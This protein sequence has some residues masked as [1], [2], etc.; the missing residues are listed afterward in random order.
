MRL[1]LLPD[2]P[3]HS[4]EGPFRQIAA[5]D[6]ILLNKTDL[7]QDELLFSE[8]EDRIAYVQVRLPEIPLISQWSGREINP[9][10]LFKRTHRSAV[11]LG[12][13]FG[14]GGYS[15]TTSA[16]DGTQK[17]KLPASLQAIQRRQ[18]TTASE[19]AN[20]GE[21]SHD[22]NGH[23]H[24]NPSNKHLNGISSYVFD[25]PVLSDIQLQGVEF[26]LQSLH[27]ENRIEGTKQEETNGDSDGKELVVL[28]SKGLFITTEGTVHILQGVRDIYELNKIDAK[29][30]ELGESQ[31]GSKLVVIGRN[32][33][34]RSRW[35][36][37]LQKT[38]SL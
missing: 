15:A 6:V 29:A 4:D 34:E 30:D 5:S 1:L 18:G 7:V 11:D 36:E 32:L 27:W 12:N 13:I 17:A 33:G 31:T 19:S 24:D 16:E 10:S 14:I 35:L 26:F 22:H 23:E 38:C 25:L 3:L 2:C 20:G 21:H 8:I 37:G 9:T 28:R